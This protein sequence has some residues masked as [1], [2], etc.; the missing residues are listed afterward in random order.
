MKKEIEIIADIGE[1]VMFISKD[2]K[3]YPAT[4]IDYAYSGL[5]NMVEYEIQF[6]GKMPS[7]CAEI[8]YVSA[9]EISL[10]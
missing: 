10:P 5:K 6:L 2:G 4:T 8:I 3:K 1:K 9:S 7:N